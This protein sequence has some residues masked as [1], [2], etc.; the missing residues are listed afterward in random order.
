MYN[1]ACDSSLDVDRHQ[2]SHRKNGIR[3][4]MVQKR[5][6]CYWDRKVCFIRDLISWEFFSDLRRLRGGLI[7]VDKVV[8]VVVKFTPF[9]HEREVFN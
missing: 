6:A 3:L 8:R 4:E 1:S 9:S 2:I 5:C 7:K